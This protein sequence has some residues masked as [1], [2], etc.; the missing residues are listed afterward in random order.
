MQASWVALQKATIDYKFI[1]KIKYRSNG[2][3]DIFKSKL[4]AKWYSQIKCINYEETFSTMVKM[5]IIKS[6]ITLVIVE[7][8][9][10]YPIDVFNALLQGNF[11]GSLYRVT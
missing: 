11:L 9:T 6:I 1:F 10:I 3:I 8:W 7:H 5:I 4:V 2:Q